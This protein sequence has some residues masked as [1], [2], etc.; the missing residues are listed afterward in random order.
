MAAKPVTTAAQQ[1]IRFGRAEQ[2]QAAVVAAVFIAAFW[3]QL[4]FV[5]PALGTLVGS[6]VYEEDWSHGP[7]IPLFSA[8]LVYLNWERVRRCRVRHTWVGLP[9]M[10]GGF[11]VYVLTQAGIVPYAYCA[12]LGMMLCLLGVIIWLCGLPVMRHAWLPWA[13]L[14]FAVPL[15][16]TVYAALTEPLRQMAA[17]V[18]EVVL[19]WL[20]GLHI[21]R[22]GTTLVYF[23]GAS[24][25][26][27]G[28]EDACSGMR[29]TI[30]LCALGVAVA[31]MSE[32][33]LWQ[34]V[35]LI[36]SC[37]PIATFCNF[38]RVTVTCWLHIF[39]DPKYASGMYHRMLGLAVILL[40]FGIFSGIGW[41][42]DHIVVED[43]EA[44]PAAG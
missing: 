43:A 20:P 29:S 24:S 38:I 40:A 22:S 36:L 5:P 4:G 2:V 33:A 16:S 32:R 27:I 35:L 23:H 44:E 17:T 8:Y 21:V 31:F 1:P 11:L 3:Y 39:V 9:L 14:F 13:Y 12:P 6:W 41:I 19:N 42:L 26:Q 10:L 15:P 7:L 18:V 28:I 37:I 25:G 30:T 34:R